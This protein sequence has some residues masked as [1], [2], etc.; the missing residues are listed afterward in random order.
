MHHPIAVRLIFSCLVTLASGVSAQAQSRSLPAEPVEIGLTPQFVFDTYI[1]DNHYALKYKRETVERVFH[2][3]TKHPS[4]PLIAGEGGYVSVRRDPEDGKFRM[5]YQTHTPRLDSQGNQKG[6]DYAIAY[7]ESSDGI[8]WNRPQ[9]NLLEWKGSRQN[10]IV[11]KGITDDRASG[12]CLL[13]V[14]VA[15]RK[16]YRYLMSYHTGGAGK[17][18]NGIRVVGSQD[19]IHWDKSSDSLLAELHSDTLNSIV[20]DPVAAQYVMYCRAKHIYRT[21]SG[22]IL[23]TG[24]S[25]RVA[26]MT[27]DTLWNEWTSEPQNILIP[28]RLDAEKQFHFFYGM[29]VRY[30]A[31]IFWGA[32]WPFKMNTDIVTELAFS[33]DGI[34]FERLPERPQLF[35]LG[36]DGSWD[37]GMVFGTDW[38]DVGDEWWFYYCGYDGPHGDPASRQ[39]GIG[40][41]TIK[42]ERLISL[43]G[44]R[45][46]GVVITRKL[47]WQGEQLLL[48]ADASQGEIKVRISDSKRKI[49]DGFD[50]QDCIPL[51]TDRL[52][53]EVKWNSTSIAAL[54]G[55]TIRLEIYLKNADLFTF[56]AG[57][58]ASQ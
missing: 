48:N 20:Y 40:L 34:Q 7:A 9:L 14:P 50:Y 15:E 28:D 45:G 2:P 18:V 31:G 46:G 1:V 47:R 23:D 25:R 49:L 4:N 42:K 16:G 26:R 8:K 11:W 3:P 12:P 6:S 21:F 32:L 54:Q 27:G 56:Q 58:K 24:A 51:K 17:G 5:W 52:R 44:P 39:P 19:G 13:D 41:A 29:P 38:V 53:H 35:A 22:A 10:N 30:H 33:R 37:D 36:E 43:H 55:Q 57:K